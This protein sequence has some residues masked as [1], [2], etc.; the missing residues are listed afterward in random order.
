MTRSIVL[1]VGILLTACGGDA[2]TDPGTAS[3][4]PTAAEETEAAA[5]GP[6]CFET[7]ELAAV[8]NEFDPGC[9]VT[10]GTLTVT[11]EGQAAHTFTVPGS[12]DVTLEPGQSEE[13]DVTE[14]AEPEGET[15]FQCTIHP[16]MQGFFW[17]Q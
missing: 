12:V 17:V 3:P 10:S 14:A 11:N 15:F 13:V 16:G 1:S 6:E 8:D 7:D 2:E 9:V 5:P 4:S